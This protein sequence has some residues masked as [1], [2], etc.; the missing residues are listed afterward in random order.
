MSE[1]T[2]AI[3]EKVNKLKA[4]IQREDN[5][6]KRLLELFP[7]ETMDKDQLLDLLNK[8]KSEKA[9]LQGELGELS[10]SE[11]H[12]EECRILRRGLKS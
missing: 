1:D 12:R 6:E 3:T 4:K 8:S 2:T 5:A 9:K 7:Y 11:A 10:K